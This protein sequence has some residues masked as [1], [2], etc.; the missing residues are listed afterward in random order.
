MNLYMFHCG[1]YPGDDI[2]EQHKNFFVTG[3]S[4]KEADKDM[5]DII[6][7]EEEKGIKYHVDGVQ[8]IKMVEGYEIKLEQVPEDHEHYGWTIID[9]GLMPM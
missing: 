6:V 7:R 9:G 1:F 2:Y 4:L 5:H 3:E 8:H